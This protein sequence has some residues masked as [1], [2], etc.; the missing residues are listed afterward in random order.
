MSVCVYKYRECVSTQRTF[1]DVLFQYISTA[2]A[3]W[4]TLTDTAHEC[5]C[6]RVHYSVCARTFECFSWRHAIDQVS[7]T[8]TACV[9][10][11]VVICKCVQECVWQGSA[12][13]TLN[14][15]LNRYQRTKLSQSPSTGSVHTHTRRRR[16]WVRLLRVCDFGSLVGRSLKWVSRN[17]K[18]VRWDRANH[19]TL[20]PI[21]LQPILA[22]I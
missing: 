2:S 11:W 5:L 20:G 15:Q 7:E 4:L 1:P 13:G 10:M 17:I 18:A 19:R 3:L 8:V 6:E 22:Y 9:C 16:H 21:T 14:H 12:A